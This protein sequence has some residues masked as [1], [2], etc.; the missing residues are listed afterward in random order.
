MA[1]ATAD[2][3]RGSCL[4]LFAFE[5]GQS[6][7]L[8]GAGRR[9]AAQRAQIQPKHRAP[10]YFRFDP[11]PLRVTQEAP[12]L[13]VA[14]RHTTPAIEI[15][16]YD[17]GAMSVTYALPFAGGFADLLDLSCALSEDAVL[18]ADARA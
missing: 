8:E 3:M 10:R 14:G 6:I 7:D 9:I 4:A 15:V 13:A 11:A 18:Q 5:V 16:L 1:D 2:R 12:A 17:F